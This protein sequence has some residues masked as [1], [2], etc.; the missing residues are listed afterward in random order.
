[1]DVITPVV[2]PPDTLSDSVTIEQH[3]N[4]NSKSHSKQLP[5]WQTGFSLQTIYTCRLYNTTA[6]PDVASEM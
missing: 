1:M 6:V 2:Q 5:S 3:A 4:Q